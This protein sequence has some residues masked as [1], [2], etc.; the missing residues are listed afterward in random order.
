MMRPDPES[1]FKSLVKINSNAELKIIK[2][3][4]HMVP[5]EKPFELTELIS[6]FIK[7]Q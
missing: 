5:L 3:C 4:G 7:K 6:A 1:F 2:S